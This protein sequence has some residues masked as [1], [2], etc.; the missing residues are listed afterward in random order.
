MVAVGAAVVGV[1]ELAAEGEVGG[2]VV[3]VEVALRAQQRI[4][5][6]ATVD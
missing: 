1:G 6:A 3:A 4:K 5:A 2:A